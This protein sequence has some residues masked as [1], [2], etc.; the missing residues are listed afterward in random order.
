LNYFLHKQVKA[1]TALIIFGIIAAITGGAIFFTNRAPGGEQTASVTP[2][3]AVGES[4]SPPEIEEPPHPVSLQAFMEKEFNGRDLE[5]GRVLADN[6]IYTRHYITYKSGG[7]T[8]S[9]I[10]NIPK[11]DGPF[12]LIVLGHGYIDPAVYTNGRGLKREQ[13]YLARKGFAVIH[14]DYRNHADSDEEDNPELRFRLGYAEDVINA[15][16]AVRQAELPSVDAERVGML[17]HSMGGG[18]ALNTIVVRPEL[19][20]AAVLFAPVSGDARDNFDRWISRRAETAQQIIEEYGSPDENPSFW[21]N[22][23]PSTFFQNVV[24]P[25]QI[26][27]G[28]ADESV[29]LEWS[30]RLHEMLLSAEK[31]AILHIYPDEPHEFIGDWPLVMSRTASFFTLYLAE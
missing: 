26:H 28:T 23:S 12:P 15:V 27:H 5:F 25:V 11:G 18:V 2:S 22:L 24:V 6:P 3:D 10:M 19:L 20:K 16:L 21:D 31:D 29:P 9:G 1:N 30:E 13:D 14:P 17:G 7:L 4:I 8:I